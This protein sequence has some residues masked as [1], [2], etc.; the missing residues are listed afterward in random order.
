MEFNETQ[1]E[2]ADDFSREALE[3][4]RT[5]AVSPAIAIP[6]EYELKSLESLQVHPDRR[7]GTVTLDE[8]GSFVAFMKRFGTVDPTTIYANKA[9]SRIVGVLNDHG[10]VP[11]WG[12]HR[13]VYVPQFS[14]EW[15]LWTAAS[16]RRMKQVEFAQFIEDNLP[17]VVVPLAADMLMIARTFEAKKKVNFASG[18]RLAN[19]EVELTYE[20]QIQGTAAKGKLQIPDGISL[21]ISV[22][23]GGGAYS[24]DCRL[25]YRIGDGGDLTMWVEMI[26]PHKILQD[27]FA[28]I[29]KEIGESLGTQVLMGAPSA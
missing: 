14:K 16:G 22:Y 21:G 8:Q 25:R 29:V 27:A 11:G 1:S 9:Q 23:E 2:I 12:D 19:G 17:D 18:I 28:T 13:A 4:E 10:D 3:A 15:A 26:R 5:G 20:E 6:P 7:R 24:V